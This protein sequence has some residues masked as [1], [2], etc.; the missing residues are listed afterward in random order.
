MFNQPKVKMVDFLQGEAD[1]Q[2]SFQK[3]CQPF[4]GRQFKSVN[5]IQ[6]KKLKIQFKFANRIVTA[7][8]EKSNPRLSTAS[9]I[10]NFY[11]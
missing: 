2:K 1:F 7:N 10:M 11:T 9:I 5:K 8:H 6:I 3:F 4:L